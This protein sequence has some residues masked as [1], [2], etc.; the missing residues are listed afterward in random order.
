MSDRPSASTRLLHGVD[1][2]RRVLM[3]LV[4]YGSVVALLVFWWMAQPKVPDGAA[5]VV[6]PTGTLVEQ[7]SP[8]DPFH[9]YVLTSAGGG[10]PAKETLLKDVVDAIRGAED[11]PR[12]KA[13]LLDLDELSAAGMTKLRDLRAALLDFRKSGKKIVAYG[14]N[15]RQPQYYL[16]AQADEVYLH[17]QGMVVLEGF[18]PWVNFYKD[19]LDRLG[20]EVHV[21]RVG[22]Y[23]SAVEPFLRNDMSPEAKE[24]ARETYGDLWRDYLADVAAG[25]KLEPEDVSQWIDSLPDR[26]RAEGGDMAKAALDG[27]LVDKLAARDEVRQR[28]IELVGEDRK[29]HTFRQVGV[30]EYL[31]ANGGDRNGVGGRGN[32]VAVVVAKG[33]IVDG[34]QPPGTIGGDS[35]ARVLRRVREDDKVKAVVLRIDSGGGSAFASEIIRR[36]CELVRK[37]GKPLVVSMGSVA[38]SGGYWIATSSDEIWADRDTITGSIGI[39]GMFPTFD[40]PLARYLGIHSDGVGTTRFTNALRSDRPLD[41]AVADMVQQLINNGYRQFLTRVAAARKMTT[42]QVDK[43]A[44]GRIWS[45]EDAKGIGLVDQLGGLDQ[46]ID[47]AAKWAKLEKGY[48]VYYVEKEM[49]LRER[50]MAALS[51]GVGELA[52]ARNDVGEGSASAV[53]PSLAAP[54]RHLQAD[55]ARLSRWNDP[56]GLYAHC[57]CTESQ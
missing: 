1:V 3:N 7:L 17:P 16:A 8:T 37:A 23:K 30:P 38:A 41:P 57:L 27:K 56:Q 5:L 52:A 42:E 47:S 21:F 32:A 44:G 20:V 15:Y 54:L 31:A 53:A 40:K 18:G 24:M 9:Q 2:L 29:N 43:V 10:P 36:E 12:I 14:D 51:A 13:I 46:A 35:T 4:S 45:G 11:D 50:I 22:S 25:R 26:L 48:R 33:D 28:M 55:V 49:T 6:K 34:D 19:G 39:F